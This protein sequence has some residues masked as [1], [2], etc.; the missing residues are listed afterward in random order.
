MSL[1]HTASSGPVLPAASGR[2]IA[3]ISINTAWNIANFRGGLIRGLQ[4]DGFEVVCA[5]PPDEHVGRLVDMG[6]RFEP[7]AMDN[8]GV[9][10]IGDLQLLRRYR[11]MLSRVRPDVY[12]GYT[13][14]P[15]VY[16]TLAAQS[17]GIPVI[18]N[19]SGLGTAFIRQNWLTHVA[20]ALYKMS[21][22]RSH[23]VFF[24]NDD[25]R[26]L[27]VG[28]GLVARERTALL[29][30]SG[31]NLE[32]FNVAPPGTS[33]PQADGSF[34]FLMIARLVH[35]KGVR[36]FVGAARVLKERRPRARCQILGFLDVENR[37]AVQRAE[38]D[39]W[40]AEGAIVYLG[41]A[42]D[43]RPFI[44]DADCVVLP[45][46]RE[47]TP[48]TLL[49]A[50]AMGKPLIATDVPG[51]REVVKHGLNGFLC[52]VRSADDLARRMIEMIDLEPEQRAELGR[53]SRAKVEREFDENLVVD[54]YRRTIAEIV[55]TAATDDVRTITREL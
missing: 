28:L 25:D 43:V 4:A 55:Q 21:F 24:Q 9:N 53:A 6:C 20:K 42:G 29:P 51:C 41:S 31:I 52:E 45:S 15:N 19:V 26:T 12:L 33:D 54:A 36:E 34:R 17:L 23:R 2:R 40:V 22:G 30:G 8:K 13:I 38:V 14:K 49:E 10:P 35:D 27:F 32:H 18:N 47:G 39:Q 5:A 48:R 16:G 50:A 3:V 1:P 46:Y 37:T 44:A 7:L 11:R